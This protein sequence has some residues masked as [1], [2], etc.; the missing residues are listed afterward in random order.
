[1]SKADEPRVNGQI[2]SASIRLVDQNGNMVGVVT[3][4]EGVRMAEQAGLDLVEI[5]PGASPPVCKILDYGK[6]RYEIQKKAHEARKKQKVIQIK[7]IKL[8]PT[9]GENDLNIKMR[10]V[11]GFLEEGDKVRITL[12]FRGREMDHQELGYQV[13]NRVQETLKDHCKIESP[14][15]TE[16]KQIAMTVGPK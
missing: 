11:L 4:A 15:R 6:Y 5:S 8:R 7:E 14:P 9:I 10:N 1:M 13:L 2:T 3:A 16:G 12:R